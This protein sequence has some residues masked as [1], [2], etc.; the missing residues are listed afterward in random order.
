MTDMEPRGTVVTDTDD[1]DALR[2]QIEQTR[3]E[4]GETVS[5]LSE[6]TD[7]KAQA[8]AKAEEVK[9]KVHDVEE[10]AKDKAHQYE[11]KAK[12][13]PVPV[14]LGA[15][16]LLFVLNKFRKRRRAG[17]VERHRMEDA[18]HRTLAGGVPVA[19]IMV[20]REAVEQAA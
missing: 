2:Q 9:A 18:L 1:P 15:L 17:R 12:Q 3:E 11:A 13:N 20:D 7:V 10:K 5:A 16:V 14:A 4:L 8:S 6:K 19:A